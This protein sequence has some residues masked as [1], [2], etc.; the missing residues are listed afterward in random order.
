MKLI[1][2]AHVNF[3]L[4]GVIRYQKKMNKLNATEGNE[5]SKSFHDDNAKAYTFL[6]SG[7]K[8]LSPPFLQY[9][10]NIS[11]SNLLYFC[12]APTLCYQLN[13]PRTPKVR[14]SFVFSYIFRMIFL[15]L[16][17]IFGIEQYIAP[18]VAEYG[19]IVEM[20]SKNIGLIFE[21]LLRLSIPNT[22]I[23]VLGSVLFMTSLLPFIIVYGVIHPNPHPPLPPPLLS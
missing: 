18:T 12:V 16:I 15:A 21:R 6:I 7:V 2:Y 4:R 11:V 22:Y 9:P 20:E 19:T 8:D 17:M 14:W 23:W 3:D 1:S 10:M 5:S 13:Y